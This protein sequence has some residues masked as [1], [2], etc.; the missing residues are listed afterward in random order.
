MRKRLKIALG[1]GG[2][3][4]MMASLFS[5]SYAWFS[6]ANRAT[7]DSGEGY[8]AASYFAGGDGTAA[9]PYLIDKPI[10]LY[11]LAWLQY[12]GY[13]NK[14]SNGAYKQ[15][16][17]ALSD[18]V[19]M[20]PTQGINW[21]LPPIGTTDNPFI[22]SFDGAGHT[23]SNLVVDNKIGDGDITRK[24]AGVESITGVNIVGTFGVVGPYNLSSSYTYSSAVNTVKN[25]YLNKVEIKSQLTQTLIGVAA[26]YVDAAISGVGI[27]DSKVTVS[28]GSSAL[29]SGP[30]TNISDYSTIGYCT[31]N[32]RKNRS[33]ATTVI[34]APTVATSEFTY[35]GTGDAAGWGGSVDMKTMYNRLFNYHQNPTR[36]LDLAA[37]PL[38]ETVEVTPSGTTTTVDSYYSTA[39]DLSTSYREYF[40]SN[41]P[42]YGSYSFGRQ[43]NS[44]TEVTDFMYLNGYRTYPN[45]ITTNTS[46]GKYNI[47][48][49]S[50]YM[51]PNGTSGVGNTTT[52][53]TQGSWDF[54]NLS[55][56]STTT[57][58]ST[59]IGGTTYYLNGSAADGLTLSTTSQSWYSY[60]SSSQGY[61]L[62]FY[63]SAYYNLDYSSGSGW[64]LNQT[65]SYIYVS[66]EKDGTSVTTTDNTT[67]SYDTYFPLNVYGTNTKGYD[68]NYPKLS[69]TGYVVSGAEVT[70]GTD[71]GYG[72]IR[73][74][75]YAMSN[76][77][78]SLNSSTYSDA[79]LEVVTRTKTSGKFVR[80]SDDYNANNTSVN[81]TIKR[82][83]YFPTKTSYTTLGLQKYQKSRA[84]LSKVLL[85][86]SY[87]YGLHFMNAAI[88]ASD[89]ATAA[90]ARIKGVD[91]T[92]YKMPRN[93]IDFNLTEKGYINFFAGT[94]YSSNTT[95][96]SLHQIFRD[97]ALGI[98]SIKEI[99]KIYTDG[100]T[101]DPF[102]Y[103]YTDGTYS[104]GNGTFVSSLPSAYGSSSSPLFDMTWVTSPKM[105]NNVM[106][107][108]E[109]PVNSGEY[110]LG[111]VTSKYG[112]YLIYL[113][114]SANA[115]QINRTSI[116]EDIVTT[117]NIYV[118][119]DGVAIVSSN[120]ET[121]NPLTG[122]AIAL[123]PAFSGSFEVSKAD[124][125]ITLTTGSAS[126][127]AGFKGDSISLAKSGSTDPPIVTPYSSSSDEIK[128]LTYVDFNLATQVTTTTIITD[129]G[130]TKTCT[131]ENGT[132]KTTYVDGSTGKQVDFGTGSAITINSLT[133]ASI[134]T[135]SYYYSAASDSIAFTFVLTHAQNTSVTTL[136]VDKVTGYAITSTSTGEALNITVTVKDGNYVI[137]INGTTITIGTVVAVP[138]TTA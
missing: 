48:S 94:Y 50:N 46:S 117:T 28:S 93:S 88:S 32:Y 36:I 8:T 47:S 107:Y 133:S 55:T 132:T 29:S 15:I 74:S 113:D 121:V 127:S 98:S 106:Y 77:N 92:N 51:V 73:V 38:T 18:D 136:H 101:S 17:F 12:L 70:S 129:H 81:S 95:F 25:V 137:T 20:D 104:T 42:L 14:T 24:P 61:N 135:Y 108:F 39:T 23:I 124:S 44:G 110:A 63:D 45:T 86:Q 2:A 62:Y 6:A 26:G 76:L 82:N 125:T 64:Y 16:Y 116:T 128:R 41:N 56:S 87:V 79:Q 114:I 1:C 75:R 35:E 5:V 60:Y 71:Y 69:N 58:I 10:H 80:I 103:L 89:Y 34:K 21:T 119:P 54:S 130:G 102:Y 53:P 33:Q 90:V 65:D 37:L 22:G 120:T 134:L 57:T 9:T 11:N 67:A 31:E 111:S 40:D 122:A 7:L 100:V 59:T 85:N 49:G 43:F 126:F 68:P 109:I 30:T 131:D 91:Y 19:D 112:A 4:L 97:D 66:V 118:Y 105:L 115:Q 3:A 13:F 52:M 123:L 78:V 99:S 138:V 72:N 84:E 96:F 27:V 83:T